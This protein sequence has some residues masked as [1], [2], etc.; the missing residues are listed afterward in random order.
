[1][2]GFKLAETV[3][4]WKPTFLAIRLDSITSR[5]LP[6]ISSPIDSLLEDPIPT[7]NILYSTMTVLL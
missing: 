5:S 4:A 3:L 1:M 6:R 7:L 2:F